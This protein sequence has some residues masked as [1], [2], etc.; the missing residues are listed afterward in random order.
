MISKTPIISLVLAFMLPFAGIAQ[1]ST[2]DISADVTEGCDSIKVKFTFIDNA[3]EDT[4]TT[5]FWDFGNGES[6]VCA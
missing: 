2:Y 6:S 1:T 3:L 5:F 4:I